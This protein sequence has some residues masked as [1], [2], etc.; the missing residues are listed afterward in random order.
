[1]FC[2]KCENILNIKSEEKIQHINIKTVESYVDFYNKNKNDF[3]FNIKTEFELSDLEKFLTFKK[4]KNTKK[5][6]EFFNTTNF[7]KKNNY[8]MICINC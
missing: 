8:I 4:N 5:I 7:V 6:I 2:N 3:S 1:M